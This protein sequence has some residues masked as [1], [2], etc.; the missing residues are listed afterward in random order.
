MWGRMCGMDSETNPTVSHLLQ[1]GWTLA[2]GSLISPG[3]SIRISKED[4]QPSNLVHLLERMQT[5]LARI[6]VAAHMC[7]PAE[8][9]VVYRDTESVVRV[10]RLELKRIPGLGN[11]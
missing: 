8:Y 11:P 5:K 10:L 7:S 4:V 3:G 1:V 9:A 6:V 2:E